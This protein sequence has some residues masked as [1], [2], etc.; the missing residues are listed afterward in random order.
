MAGCRQA[1]LPLSLTTGQPWR[2]SGIPPTWHF[3]SC[4]FRTGERSWPGRRGTGTLREPAEITRTPGITEDSEDNVPPV[5]TALS[6]A[7]GSAPVGRHQELHVLEESLRLARTSARIVSLAGEPWVGSAAGPY[8][9]QAIPRML[10]APSF[11]K[12]L[13]GQCY[14]QR[15]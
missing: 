6:Q 11:T 2:K 5:E 8:S 13:G 7:T 12:A 10:S 3:L 14:C 4:R 1:H 15:A 9:E